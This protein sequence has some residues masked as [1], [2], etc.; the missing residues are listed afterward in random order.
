MKA[1]YQLNK[2]SALNEKRRALK[3]LRNQRGITMTEVLLGLTLVAIIIAILVDQYNNANEST[4][5]QQFSSEITTMTAQSRIWKGTAPNYT[6]ISVTALTSIGRLDNNWGAGTGVNP[7]GGNYTLAANATDATILDVTAT[8]MTAAMCG[9]VARMIQSRTVN[10][11]S[12][13]CTGGTLTGQF[14]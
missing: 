11:S 6:G 1:H 7:A 10:G 4:V 2:C 13:S 3:K 12:A 8:G 9:N 14:R 5:A